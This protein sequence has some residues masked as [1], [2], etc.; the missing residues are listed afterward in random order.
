MRERPFL[1]GAIEINTDGRSD[2]LVDVN[3][4]DF[5]LIPKENGSSRIGGYQGPYLNWN[6]EFIHDEK[7]IPHFRLRK[8]GGFP[9]GKAGKKKYRQ[10][11]AQNK[12]VPKNGKNHFSR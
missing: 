4:K 5:F 6:N 2:I 7:L 12:P 3:G 10:R 9:I 8:S 1:L 11:A